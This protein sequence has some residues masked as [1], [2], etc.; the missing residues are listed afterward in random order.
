MAHRS[1]ASPHQPTARLRGRAAQAGRG[2]ARCRRQRARRP[3]STGGC[4]RSRATFSAAPRCA[5]PRRT[6]FASRWATSAGAHAAHRPRTAVRRRPARREPRQRPIR[7][8]RVFDALH[9]RSERFADADALRRAA[10]SAQSAAAADAPAGTSSTST[11]GIARSRTSSSRTLVEIAVGV[12]TSSR[13]QTVWQVRVL[14]EDAGAGTTCARPTR[15]SPAGPTLIAPSTGR[16]TTGTFEVAAG[17]RSLRAAADRRL[18]RAREPA[19]P[20]RDPRSPAS[21]AAR[22]TFKWSRE[23]ASVGSR[24]ASVIS[25]T[26]L[27]LDD[28]RPRRRAALQHRRLG[29]D[30]RRRA[31]VRADAGRDAQDHRGRGD[32]P[33]HVHAAAAGGHVARRFPE[34]RTSRGAQPARAPLGPA[35]RGA[36][37]PSQRHAGRC[38]RISTPPA[39][40][41]SSRCRPR[42]RRCCSRTAS[43]SRSPRPAPKGFR[44]GDYWVFAA[45]TADASVELLDRAPPRGIHHHYARL[46]IW[47]VG[48]GDGRPTAATTGRRPPAATTA[49]A[50]SASRPSRTPAASSRSRT[51]YT[52]CARPAARSVWGRDST[53]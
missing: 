7:P 12:E 8:R 50:R 47:D 44:A 53:L 28:A 51:P 43:P 52:R 25:A 17:R 21:P 34:H 30:P 18:S 38:S 42:A 29:R 49:A 5:R 32:A 36:S 46:G 13:L 27:E 15:S 11:S 10:L 6:P 3:S 24:V 45:R 9:G 26:E 1:L 16:L 41:A 37:A 33:H 48:A 20:R 39:R 22:R 14:A 4:A 35:R 2:A 40:P 23:N 31:R 19:L